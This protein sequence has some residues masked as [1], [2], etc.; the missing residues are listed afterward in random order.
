LGSPFDFCISGV[1]YKKSAPYRRKAK[2]KGRMLFRGTTF[3]LRETHS[4][5]FKKGSEATFSQRV[6][7]EPSSRE[8][9]GSILC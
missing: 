8:N 4:T 1:W 5:H 6:S 3:I 9:P 2:T 7:Q